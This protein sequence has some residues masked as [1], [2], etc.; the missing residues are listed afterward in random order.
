MAFFS[1]FDEFLS[2]LMS[3]QSFSANCDMLA[4]KISKTS[5][6]QFGP[7]WVCTQNPRFQVPIPPLILYMYYN[8]TALTTHLYKECTNLQCI[9]VV[10][11]YVVGKSQLESE[12][13]LI[14][15]HT[16]SSLFFF[17]HCQIFTTKGSYRLLPSLNNDFLQD[18]NGRFCILLML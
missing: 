1:I 17:Q 5:Q 18:M 7:K 13:V 16:S 2:D 12:L 8:I 15:E 9:L 6:K 3:F 14:L 4:L 11:S 10:H